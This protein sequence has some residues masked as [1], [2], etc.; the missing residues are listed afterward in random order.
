MADLYNELYGAEAQGKAPAGGDL[1]SKLYG[2]E[3][4][5][6]T[7]TSPTTGGAIFEPVAQMVTGSVGS[8]VGG[9][10][11]FADVIRGKS[12]EEATKTIQDIQQAM[13]YQPRTEAGKTLSQ[14]IAYPFEKASE[15]LGWVGGKIGGAFGDEAAGEAIGESAIPVAATLLGARPAMAVGSKLAKQAATNRAAAATSAAVERV[16]AEPG[17]TLAVQQALDLPNPILLNPKEAYNTPL[18]RAVT[19]MANE[20]KLD[21]ALIEANKPAFTANAKIQ[22]GMD[23]RTALSSKAYD[24][25]QA[26][27][28]GPKLEVASIPKFAP[29]TKAIADLDALKKNFDLVGLPDA[30]NEV[31]PAILHA[32]QSIA[33]GITGEQLMAS[34]EELRRVS[35][36]LHNKKEMGK[37][38]AAVAD[39]SIGIANVLEDMVERHLQGTGRE[40]LL[41]QYRDFRRKSAIAYAYESATDKNHMMIDPQKLAKVTRADNAFTGEARAMGNIAGVFKNESRLNTPRGEAYQ[42]LRRSTVPA[43]IGGLIGGAIG[44][45]GGA[46]VGISAG[47]GLSELILSP[48]ARRLAMSRWMQERARPALTSLEGEAVPPRSYV[49]PTTRS[50]APGFEPPPFVPGSF[51]QSISGK[52]DE[53]LGRTPLPE[54]PPEVPPN[55]LYG[56]REPT[57]SAVRPTPLPE[58]PP[59]ASAL[60]DIADDLPK[61]TSTAYKGAVDFM[62]RQDALQHPAIAQ[63]TMQFVAEAERLRSQINS[64]QGFWKNRYQAELDALSTEFAQGM[65]QMGVR[66]PQEAIGLQPLYQGGETS[67]QL[68]LPI[69][70]VKTLRDLVP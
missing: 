9:L 22:M 31:N 60:L 57:A 53:G 12:A 6:T 2:S 61:G 66:N 37:T 40:G 47:A 26:S 18:S 68:R 13:T 54:I 43:T 67:A 29:D 65:L 14:A 55:P 11:G 64:A 10:A 39:A 21:T 50:F 52:L 4:A 35:R 44:G 51:A 34:I 20:S 49:D 27:I 30:F 19:T 33:S 23:E 25:Y 38:D 36:N 45:P 56:F 58:L 5:P 46:A 7:W 15:G 28:A 69:E 16:M 24:D 48:A 17:K 59:V 8:A 3:P 41:N 32:Q 70:K 63:A 1:Y 62:L 42:L